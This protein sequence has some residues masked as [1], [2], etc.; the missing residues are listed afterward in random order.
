MLHFLEEKSPLYK[1]ISINF[2][3]YLIYVINDKVRCTK[4]HLHTI[5]MLKKLK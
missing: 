5:S 4:Y 1:K 3:S 2:I